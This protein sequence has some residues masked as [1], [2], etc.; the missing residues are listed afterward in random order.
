M[1]IVR[2]V[3]YHRD[4]PRQ[5]FKADEQYHPQKIRLVDTQNKN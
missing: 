4:W 5:G 1:L 3:D 2:P